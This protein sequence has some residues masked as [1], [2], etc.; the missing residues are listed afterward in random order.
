MAKSVDFGAGCVLLP[1]TSFVAIGEL[2]SHCGPRFP[3]LY[4]GANFRIYLRG[5]MAHSKREN[6]DCWPTPGDS[7]SVALS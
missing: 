2:P 5:C 6:I 7:G 4:N 3:H 1:L